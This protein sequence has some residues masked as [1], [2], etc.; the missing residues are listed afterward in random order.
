MKGNKK[1][2]LSGEKAGQDSRDVDANEMNQHR[3]KVER[4]TDNEWPCL[5]IHRG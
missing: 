4:K 3:V 2:T 5:L 1:P